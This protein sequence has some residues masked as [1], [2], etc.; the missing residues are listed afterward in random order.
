MNTI[1]A[2][3]AATGRRGQISSRCNDVNARVA[4]ATRFI[5]SWFAI[6]F[7][8]GAS[9]HAAGIGT[10]VRSTALRRRHAMS[11]KWVGAREK[12][13][14]LRAHAP[15]AVESHLDRDAVG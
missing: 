1:N 8:S 12:H 10:L 4:P 7:N 2:A 5:Q 3:T 13:D 14:G 6:S 9:S 15:V 11:V